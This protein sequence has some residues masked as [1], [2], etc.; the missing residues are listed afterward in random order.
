[1]EYAVYSTRGHLSVTIRRILQI[2]NDIERQIAFE[3]D[4]VQNGRIRHIESTRH[5]P[6]TGRLPGKTLLGGSLDSL[7]DAILELQRA[8]KT[9]QLQ[10]LPAYGLLLL[11][12]DQEKF[13]LITLGL[14]VNA[15][16]TSEFKNGS[17]P[18]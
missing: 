14:L 18:R 12:L 3:A 8:L 6:A 1:M 11:S 17:M 13:A 2:M 10:K 16:I 5:E 15:I 4:A 7:A 9:S